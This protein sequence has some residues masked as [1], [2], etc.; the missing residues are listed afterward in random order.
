MW[1]RLKNLRCPKCNGDIHSGTLSD[2][3]VCKECDFRINRAKFDKIVGDLYRPR[4]QRDDV[5]ENLEAWNN[6]R[7]EEREAQHDSAIEKMFD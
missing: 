5:E 4:A 7:P 2:E 6:Y 3:M 1:S